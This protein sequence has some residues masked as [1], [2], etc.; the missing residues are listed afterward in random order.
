MYP[1]LHSKSLHQ[2][3]E[4]N[5]ALPLIFVLFIIK[6]LLSH[7]L[8]DWS[9]QIF[10]LTFYLWLYFAISPSFSSL[11]HQAHYTLSNVCVCL[12]IILMTV[13]KK[14]ISSSSSGQFWWWA[15]PLPFTSSLPWSHSNSPALGRAGSLCQSPD[16]WTFHY[17]DTI[18]AM[19]LWGHT[20]CILLRNISS[21][22]ESKWQQV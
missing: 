17:N 7:S 13:P 10:K 3:T 6:S 1:P 11:Y 9:R 5:T 4:K 2:Y 16:E 19:R 14:S 12:W 22:R 15:L 20:F 21:S 18:Y 8:S